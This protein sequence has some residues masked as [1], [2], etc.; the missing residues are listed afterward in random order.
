MTIDKEL[1]LSTVTNGRKRSKSMESGL[2]LV[3]TLILVLFVLVHGVVKL[4]VDALY[5]VAA[6]RHYARNARHGCTSKEGKKKKRRKK[7]SFK[8]K[9][10]KRRRMREADIL[11]L[12]PCNSGNAE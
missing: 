7:G 1:D 9:K 10:K 5:K 6:K 8:V 12:V 4:V 11:L 3:F 2:I